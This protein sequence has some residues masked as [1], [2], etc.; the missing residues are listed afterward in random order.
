MSIELDGDLRLKSHQ[1]SSYNENQF[2]FSNRH[3]MKTSLK[4]SLKPINALQIVSS[5]KGYMGF[6]IQMELLYEYGQYRFIPKPSFGV[7]LSFRRE[8]SKILLRI[9]RKSITNF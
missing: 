5:L 3:T 9:L 7:I 8:S 2:F 4:K 6:P 1:Q